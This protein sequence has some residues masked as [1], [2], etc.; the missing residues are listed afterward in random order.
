MKAGVYFYA[1]E[2]IIMKAAQISKYGDA[3][4]IT[5]NEVDRPVPGP[6]EV[7]VEV[8]SASLNPFDT[9]IREGYLSER[10]PLTLP[11]TLGGDIAGVIAEVGQGVR[12]F[13]AGDLV[14]G[15][16]GA[17]FG[18][19]GA[20]AEF[21]RTG[22]DRIAKAPK[23]I[24]F[25]EAA[26]LVLVGA[27]ALQALRDHLNLKSG[28]T[29]F[30]HGGGGGIGSVAIQVAKHIGARV[31]TTAT[32][33]NI[34]YVTGLGADKVIDYKAQEF[35]DMVHDAD[36]VL[37]VVG[38]EDLS[39]SF[40]ILRKGGTAVSTVGPVDEKRASELGV[41]AVMQFT[42]A[43]PAVLDALRELIEKGIVKPRIGRVFA[44]S[45]AREA[46]VAHETGTKGKIVLQIHPSSA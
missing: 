44:L 13:K 11:V 17:Y 34:P 21:A 33:E 22:A 29:I 1:R 15:Q 7:V 30:I 24:D 2:R 43:T 39:R 23:N 20:F 18:A 12:E 35:A 42:K 5:I 4:A 8:R 37:D 45:D 16:A 19:S 6:G 31:I 27:S 9:M 3:S 14:Y 28:E 41:K 46:F 38:G 36:A 10:I 25:N 32:G 40:D 26:S